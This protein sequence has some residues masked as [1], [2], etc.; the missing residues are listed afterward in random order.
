MIGL[1]RGCGV[2]CLLLV[3]LFI[4]NS[5]AAGDGR[6]GPSTPLQSVS[7]T[8][9]AEASTPIAPA[10]KLRR[11]LR[12]L[13]LS[14]ATGGAD[15]AGSYGPPPFGEHGCF[16]A[17][18]EVSIMLT[19]VYSTAPATALAGPWWGSKSPTCRLITDISWGDMLFFL[20]EGYPLDE[21]VRIT[22]AGPDGQED[23]TARVERIIHL[24]DGTCSPQRAAARVSIVVPP[25][26]GEGAYRLIAEGSSGRQVITFNVTAPRWP[27]YGVQFGVDSHPLL[28]TRG[29]KL[30]LVFAGF[31]PEFTTTTLIFRNAFS[32]TD[33]MVESEEPKFPGPDGRDSF[34]AGAFETTVNGAG[35]AIAEVAWPR[36]L[37]RGMYS[38]STPDVIRTDLRSPHDPSIDVLYQG[39]EDSIGNLAAAYT[40][41]QFAARPDL[42]ADNYTLWYNEKIGNTVAG[43]RK[44]LAGQYWKVVNVEEGD[45]LNVRDRPGGKK[46]GELHRNAVHIQVI[47]FV[48]VPNSSPWAEIRC[49]SVNDG[50]FEGWVNSGYIARQD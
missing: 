29:E 31:P 11:E 3:A 18:E 50:S 23:Y 12:Q 13:T 38:L 5:F 41:I 7:E 43:P 20:V 37:G 9:P 27:K 21:N 33:I 28:L 32:I 42:D 19:G 46:I 49:F 24:R 40:T 35:W 30:R 16:S 25:T 10:E 36:D 17:G 48:E 39:G 15:A 2:S 34:V 22:L 1:V 47:Q 8:T 4:T 44:E 6:T 45:T 26:L 14:F